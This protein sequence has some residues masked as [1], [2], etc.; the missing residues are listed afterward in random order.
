MKKIVFTLITFAI[1]TGACTKYRDVPNK[2]P[3]FVPPP[4]GV[5]EYGSLRINEF[6]CHGTD[7]A[8]QTYLGSNA[9]WFELYNPTS[10]DVVLT[11]GQWYVTDTLG[12][13]SGTWNKFAIPADTGVNNNY[14]VPAHGFLVI[15]CPK[16]GSTTPS[17][18]HINTSFSL[19]SS[20]G[21]I[22]VYYQ[23]SASSPI[24]AI[25]TL[26]Y[27]ISSNPPTPVSYGRYPDGQNNPTLQ[28]GGVTA[29]KP[30]VQ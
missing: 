13:A 28:R 16:T 27:S 9:K 5:I 15:M 19:S 1:L 2:T 23:Q 10:Q 3:V 11:H 6:I 17:P 18:N 12:R 8:S 26:S 30:N 14:K 22:G 20:V 24:I 4:A 21:S 25:D 29:E 7:P